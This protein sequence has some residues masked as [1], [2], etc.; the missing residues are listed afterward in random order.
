MGNIEVTVKRVSE[1]EAILDQALEIM[2]NAEE[3][4]EEFFGFQP[5]IKKL[6]AYYQSQDWKDD[7]ALDDEGVLP[8][9]L[10][11]GVLSEDG[12]YYALE[13][14]KEL[15]EELWAEGQTETSQDEDADIEQI[16]EALSDCPDLVQQLTDAYEDYSLKLQ[17]MVDASKQTLEESGS[18]YLQEKDAKDLEMLEHEA[19][20]EFLDK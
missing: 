15:L 17:C 1:M 14:N 6:E 16:L 5:E 10:K 8:E 4:K 11:R 9:G 7:F 18:E 13:K 3:N 2:N 19:K 20:V 12:I